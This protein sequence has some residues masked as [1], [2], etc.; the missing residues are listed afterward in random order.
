MQTKHRGVRLSASDAK[1][2]NVSDNDQYKQ[3]EVDIDLAEIDMQRDFQ[4]MD[5]PDSVTESD[6]TGMKWDITAL[7]DT[8]AQ[9]GPD[10]LAGK[11]SPVYDAAIMSAALILWHRG[12]SI[13]MPAAV[14]LAKSAVDSG[15]ALARLKA[16][17]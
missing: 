1:N 5:I 10:A 7:A 12:L 4:A 9:A 17:I 15:E 16:A 6:I 3:H 11:Q 13:D 2:R 14:K 8:C